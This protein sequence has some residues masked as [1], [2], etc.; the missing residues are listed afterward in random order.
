VR[1]VRSSFDVAVLMVEHH[2]NFVMKVS[3]RV[4]ALNFGKTLAE[5]TPAEMQSN[6]EVI[7]AYLG[8]PA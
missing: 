3:D 7:R 1:H 6:P 8:A 2:L 4:V 5:G